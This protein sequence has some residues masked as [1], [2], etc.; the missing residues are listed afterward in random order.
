[1]SRASKALAVLVVASLGLW[2]CAQG[3]SNGGVSLERVRALES[4]NAK[5]EDDFR[6]AVAVRDQL[7]KKVAAL[8]DQ[9]NQLTQQIE[10]LAVAV[11]ERDEARQLASARTNERDTLQGQIDSLRKGIRTLLG[12]ADAAASAAPAA[13][14]T[15][16]TSAAEGQPG[17][18]S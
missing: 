12:Q 9:R 18:K 11:K 4:K 5:L 7:K 8:E 2:G 10:Q 16:V 14:A 15:P 3:P 6:A 17:N 1:M 13:P